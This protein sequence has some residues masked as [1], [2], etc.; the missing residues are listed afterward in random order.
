MGE[1]PLQTSNPKVRATRKGKVA[2]K[3]RAAR[4]MG[5]AVG[6]IRRIQ[7]VDCPFSGMFLDWEKRTASV[8]RFSVSY[9]RGTHVRNGADVF[10]PPP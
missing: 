7:N 4:R 1:A 8:L 3:T 6:V 2:R 5:S 10:H 9:E